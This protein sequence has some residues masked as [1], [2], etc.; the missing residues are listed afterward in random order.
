M[1]ISDNVYQQLMSQAADKM[2]ELYDK[3][4]RQDEE[5]TT[6]RAQLAEAKGIVAVLANLDEMIQPDGSKE[7]VS[8]SIFTSTIK[9]AR[10]WYTKVITA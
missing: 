1:K 3:V 7:F 4:K 5:I 10:A 9:K 2:T 8:V 6:L